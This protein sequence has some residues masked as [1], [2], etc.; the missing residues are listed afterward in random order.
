MGLCPKVKDNSYDDDRCVT[1]ILYC[2]VDPPVKLWCAFSVC[3]CY[4][5]LNIFHS[6]LCLR[7]LWISYFCYFSEEYD[8]EPTYYRLRYSV[9]SYL[10]IVGEFWSKCFYSKGLIPLGNVSSDRQNCNEST[11]M[12]TIK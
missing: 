5:C 4:F 12:V 10:C 11:I 7:K 9:N 1:S 3:V 8:I 2:I 6:S